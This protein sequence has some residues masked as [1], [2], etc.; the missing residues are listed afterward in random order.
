MAL[1]APSLPPSLSLA[2][3]LPPPRPS[4]SCLHGNKTESVHAPLRSCHFHS[5]LVFSSVP[6]LS[7][8]FLTTLLIPTPL[9]TSSLPSRPLLPPL[10]TFPFFFSPLPSSTLLSSSSSS[11]L[12]SF[13]FL[14]SHLLS[15]VLSCL[16]SLVSSSSPS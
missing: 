7:F 4:T 1:Q 11:P 6:L 3:P 9:P 10:P 5:S 15:P 8:P 14:T 13:P 12:H 2:S 16:I